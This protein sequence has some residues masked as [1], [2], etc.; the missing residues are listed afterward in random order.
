MNEENEILYNELYERT[1]DFGRTHFIREIMRLQ[2]ENA[3]LKEHYNNMFECHCNRVQVEK[4]QNNWNELKKFAEVEIIECK[5]IISTI[6]PEFEKIML[7]S[8]GKTLLTNEY[9]KTQTIIKCFEIMLN[10][11]Q[12]LEGNND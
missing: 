10:K 5:A 6:L 2:Q 8:S 4:L 7:R 11:M 1:K 12:E 3:D 9:N